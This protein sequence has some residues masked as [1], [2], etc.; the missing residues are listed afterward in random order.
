[1]SHQTSDYISFVS[2]K[3]ITDSTVS[4]TINCN[5]TFKVV[6]IY[7]SFYHPTEGRRL[8]RLRWL[9]TY[10]DG[11]PVSRQSPIQVVT[12][13][14]VEQLRWSRPTCSSQHTL[15]HTTN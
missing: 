4:V 14:S 2:D 11:L 5:Q 6:G 3:A 9:D 10:R 15:H 1:M 7:Y 8:S 13:P 12:A